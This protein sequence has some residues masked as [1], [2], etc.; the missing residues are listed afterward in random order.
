LTGAPGVAAQTPPLCRQAK[1]LLS[2]LDHLACKTNGCLF[3]S[4]RVSTGTGNLFTLANLSSCQR[5]VIF[6]ASIFYPTSL[7]FLIYR[8]IEKIALYLRFN[9]AG[10]TAHLP[11]SRPRFSALSEPLFSKRA[12]P[13]PSQKK[14]GSVRPS[15]RTFFHDPSD[16]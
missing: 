13:P 6:A 2:P 16:W 4:G 12:H 8:G 1:N 5:R 3:L 15:D 11:G 7:R 9:H 10:V 14:K